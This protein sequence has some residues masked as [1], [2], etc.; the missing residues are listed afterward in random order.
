[1]RMPLM[2]VSLEKHYLVFKVESQSVFHEHCVVSIRQPSHSKRGVPSVC[3]TSA[4]SMQAADVQAEI[5]KLGHAD[6]SGSPEGRMRRLHT[7]KSQS[8]GRS[9]AF[10][11][12]STRRRLAEPLQHAPSLAKALTL[13]AEAAGSSEGLSQLPED[14]RSDEYL[15]G[16][17]GMCGGATERHIIQELHTHLRHAQVW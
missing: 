5:T 7:S 13:G 16:A 3:N 8:P 2:G 9:A 1:M 12:S 15:I 6:R 10:A 4:M 17:L 14:V 11:S